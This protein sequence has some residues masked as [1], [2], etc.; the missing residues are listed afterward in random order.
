MTALLT[1]QGE[2]AATEEIEWPVRK[3]QTTRK[4]QRPHSHK[5]DEVVVTHDYY[6]VSFDASVRKHYT[7]HVDQTDQT[8]REVTPHGSWL[9][10]AL[11]IDQESV[12]YVKHD[13]GKTSRELD[14]ERNPRWKQKQIVEIKAHARRIPIKVSNLQH[15]ITR[16]IASAYEQKPTDE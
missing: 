8:E 11:E 7:P 15:R 5:Y 9:A 14:P 6:L 10:A 13:F 4:V 12:I 2:F 1:I 3:E 16:V